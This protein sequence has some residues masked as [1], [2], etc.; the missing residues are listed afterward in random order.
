MAIVNGDRKNPDA[1]Q[2]GLALDIHQNPH[3]NFSNRGISTRVKE[4]TIT[5]I[6]DLRGLPTLEVMAPVPTKCRVFAPTAE[7]PEAVLVVRNMG[8]QTLLHVSPWQADGAAVQAMMG[9]CYVAT[10]D[11]RWTELL[12]SLLGHGFYGALPLH[13][14]WER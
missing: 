13:D 5:R 9:G 11:S 4:L 3:G 7:R 10:S 1:F 14:R 8:D 2:R 6:L 12:E